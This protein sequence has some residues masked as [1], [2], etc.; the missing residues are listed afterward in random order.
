[1]G[2][3]TK[4]SNLTHLELGDCTG[5]VPSGDL[6]QTLGASLERLVHLRVERAPHL[7]AE[8]L[9]ELR[10]LRGLQNLELI[11][12]Q[13]KEGFGEGLVKMQALKKLLLIP[14]YKDEV[15][16]EAEILRNSGFPIFIKDFR[17]PLACLGS[18]A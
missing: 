5:L 15:Q 9:G 14:V 18:I 13:L 2:H 12:V 7:A 11:D 8:D 6:L 3:L 17:V 4:L 1:M 16:K 10:L